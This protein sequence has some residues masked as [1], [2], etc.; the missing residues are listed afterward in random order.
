ME[1]EKC[2]DTRGGVGHGLSAKSDTDNVGDRSGVLAFS[3]VMVL[4]G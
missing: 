3:F 4:S 2:G 1:E